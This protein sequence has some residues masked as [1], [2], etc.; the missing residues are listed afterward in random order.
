M[1]RL[2]DKAITVELA[3][4]MLAEALRANARRITIDEIQK[5]CAAHYRIDQSEM[6][7]APARA[8]PSPGRDRSP[9]ISPRS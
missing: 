4:T 8:G 9:C 5:V 7:L 3:Q 1:P 6:R 2:M